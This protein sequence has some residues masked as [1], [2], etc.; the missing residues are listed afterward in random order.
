[1]TEEKKQTRGIRNNNPMNIRKT[2][3]RW[4][5]QKRVQTD[6]SF[7]EFESAE[8]GYR[9]AAKILASYARRGIDTVEGI[10][11]TWAPHNENPTDSYVK[12]VAKWTGFKPNQK[13]KFES[14]KVKLFRAMTIFE[15]GSDHFDE[16]T[17]RKGIRLA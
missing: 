14:D 12:F 4:I 10:V 11:K 13:I 16:A 5:G 17:I 6:K 1:M 15:S 8:Y 3:I 9:A 2:D 7:V